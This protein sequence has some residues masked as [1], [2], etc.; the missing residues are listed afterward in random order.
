MP[1]VHDEADLKFDAVALL[2]V[3]AYRVAN[4]PIDPAKREI[5][6]RLVEAID[7]A[8]AIAKEAK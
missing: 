8:I 7:A 1:R 6:Q 5:A 4:M 2:G 3:K